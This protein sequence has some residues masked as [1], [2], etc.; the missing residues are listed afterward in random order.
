MHPDHGSTGRRIIHFLTQAGHFIKAESWEESSNLVDGH[1]QQTFK[2][3][4]VCIYNADACNIYVYIYIYVCAYID[5]CMYLNI[6]I[7]KQ[8]NR[9]RKKPCIGPSTIRKKI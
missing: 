1:I 3:I 7:Y 2:K 4:G 9:I 5:T 8:F 6:Y